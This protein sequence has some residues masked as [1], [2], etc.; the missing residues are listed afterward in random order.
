MKTIK[1]TEAQV[2][3]MLEKAPAT[4]ESDHILFIRLCIEQARKN[5]DNAELIARVLD[6]IMIHGKEN[7]YPN[8]ESVGRARR[9]LQEKDHRLQATARTKK[10]RKDREIVFKEYGLDM[11]Q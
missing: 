10:G 9:K 4:R 7:G 6:H 5:R 11:K 8:F 1:N 2:R 3:A